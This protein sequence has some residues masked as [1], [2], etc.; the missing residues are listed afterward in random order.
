MSSGQSLLS[1]DTSSDAQQSSS[2][3]QNGSSFN[4]PLATSTNPF[5][6]SSKVQASNIGDK[7][8]SL[9]EGECVDVH[10]DQRPTKKVKVIEN[11]SAAAST[12]IATDL[13]E[14]N[15]TTQAIDPALQIQSQERPATSISSPLSSNPYAIYLTNN[16]SGTGSALIYPPF[17][18]PYYYLA[19]PPTTMPFPGIPVMPSI[20]THSP[21]VAIRPQSSFTPPTRSSFVGVQPEIVHQIPVPTQNST[22][23]T[24]S[25]DHSQQSSTPSSSKPRRLKSH[26]VVTK[27]HSIPTVPRDKDGKPML[28]LNVGIMTVVRLGTICFREHFH[29]ERYI[30]PVG[31]TV[32]RRYLSTLDP[33]AEVVYNCTILD[34]GD[35][36]K[37]QIIPSDEP[38]KPIIASTATGAWSSIVRKANEIRSRQH[39][40][41]VSGPDFFGLGQNTIRHLIQQLPG[42]ERLAK[43]GTQEGEKGDRRG[44]DGSRRNRIYV[45]QNYIEGGPLGGRHAAVTPAL[46]EDYCSSQSSGFPGSLGSNKD[47]SEDTP[48]LATAS[49]VEGGSGH[50]TNANFATSLRS[51]TDS[52]GTSGRRSGLSHY[53]S[54]VRVQAEQQISPQRQGKGYYHDH[55][56]QR[57]TSNHHSIHDSPRHPEYSQQTYLQVQQEQMTPD[58]HSHFQDNAHAQATLASLLHTLAGVQDGVDPA[59][60]VTL[61]L[62]AVTNVFSGEVSGRNNGNQEAGKG[63]VHFV[64]RG[65][66]DAETPLEVVNAE[67]SSL[68]EP[69]LQDPSVDHTPAHSETEFKES[70]Q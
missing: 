64:E 25:M 33:H 12:R 11:S 60:F 5:A 14:S 52:D 28:P 41:S 51:P 59:N 61:D 40:N 35:G 37:F 67:S 17:A 47:V 68:H 56:P 53:P 18:N 55:P 32:T 45:W 26:A 50:G 3:I 57:S 4:D 39:S 58:L 16:R 9:V 49:D 43:R 20:Y 21:P 10:D 13:T 30:F 69:G 70:S 66:A 1:S 2:Y 63:N 48:A 44:N 62:P 19:L 6:T 7:R 15:T 23:G 36:P 34:G 46:P 22:S 8:S 54:R 24:N 38:D 65:R 42:A 27:S 29:S 31:Y